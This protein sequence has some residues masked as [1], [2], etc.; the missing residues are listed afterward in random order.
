M[1][2]LHFILCKNL[3]FSLTF[4]IKYKVYIQYCVAA[5]ISFKFISSW[6]VYWSLFTFWNWLWK[7]QLSAW[8]CSSQIC[9]NTHRLFDDIM[10]KYCSFFIIIL[11]FIFIY[12][13]C[14]SSWNIFDCDITYQ[15]W[16]YFQ[17]N[18][19]FKMLFTPVP[20]V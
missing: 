13:G 8:F 1:G 19:D 3:C 4:R 2:W 6:I 17:V 15:F 7:G 12:V 14:V 18:Y 5:L 9:V 10:N 16:I 20:V 11:M